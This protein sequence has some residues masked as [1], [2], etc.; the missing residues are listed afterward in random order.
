MCSV[1]VLVF[2][3]LNFVAQSNKF[4]E[5]VIIS[6]PP[7]NDTLCVNDTVMLTCQ[8]SSATQPTYKWF[9]DKFNISDH[10]S[11]IKVIATKD[12]VEYY[13]TVFDVVTSR[14]G[15]G[16]ITVNGY[17]KLSVIL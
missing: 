16:N 11:S 17:G 15:E 14:S 1:Y 9:S 13:C 3:V 7:I 10:A 12:P 8:A 6:N 5:V 4:L 2:I